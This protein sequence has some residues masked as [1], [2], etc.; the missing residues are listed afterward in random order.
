MSDPLIVGVDG[1][2]SSLG[3]AEPAAREAHPREVPLRLVRAFG[4]PSSQLIEAGREA[5]PVSAGAGGRGGFTGLPPGPAGQALPH[6]PHC[7][8]VAVRGKE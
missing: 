3:A 5:Q 1:P 6:H 4:R 7:P 8:V 2:A